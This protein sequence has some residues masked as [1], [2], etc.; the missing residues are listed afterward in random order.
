MPRSI[1][2]CFHEKLTMD[3]LLSAHQRASKA[4]RCS[5][6]VLL[7][8]I[9]LESNLI[10]LYRKL[11][12]GTYHIGKYRSFII[13]EPKK[14][15]IKSLPYVDRLVHQWYIEEFIKPFILPRFIRDTYACLE[16]RGTHL[17][18]L[19]LQ[20][21]MRRMNYQ[22]PDYYIVKFDI[23]KFFY[24]IDRDILYGILTRC[25]SDK[26][27]LSLTYQLIYDDDEKVGIPIGNY[28]S[29]FF[30]NIYLNELDHYVKEKMKVKYYVR[31]MDDFIMLARDKEEAKRW[32]LE[33]QQFIQTRL[34]L[35]LNHKSR[36]YPHKMGVDFCGFHI[37]ET[38]CRLRKSSKVRM[39]KRVKR[40]NLLYQN[41]ILDM[42]Q[43]VRCWNSWL[44]HSNHANSYFLQQKIYSSILFKEYLPF[45]QKEENNSGSIEGNVI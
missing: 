38:H 13:Y 41:H 15:L 44:A 14:R 36:Y 33:V 9:D 20:K 6:E 29:Q 45:P 32:L 27:L 2:K 17:A 39:K 1:N 5:K 10:N 37:F 3:L 35:T 28:T 30:A 43:A 23:Q 26:D 31:Y 4:K 19:N 25:I 21:Y 34:H 24:S 22:Y 12:N 11:K 7:F 40:W 8:E 42:D 16:N 18:I